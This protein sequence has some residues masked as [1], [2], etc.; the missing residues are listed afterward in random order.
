MKR[1]TVLIPV[2]LPRISDTAALQLIDILEQLLD[3][4]RHHYAPQ[5]QRCQRRQRNRAHT[6]KPQPPYLDAGELF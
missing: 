4:V 5:I 3:C 6:A 1:S 2:L